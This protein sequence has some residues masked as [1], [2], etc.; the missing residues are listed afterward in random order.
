MFGR[1]V[2]MLT[3]RS[4]HDA[5]SL[6]EEASLKAD[7]GSSIRLGNGGWFSGCLPLAGVRVP[8]G[9]GRGKSSLIVPWIRA[10]ASSRSI[11]FTSSV[12]SRSSTVASGSVNAPT[13]F[14]RW[15]GRPSGSMA[16]GRFESSDSGG[17]LS[18]DGDDDDGD[19]DV[20]VAV[21]VVCCP[22]VSGPDQVVVGDRSASSMTSDCHFLTSP[23]GRLHWIGDMRCWRVMSCNAS[24]LRDRRCALK[25][26]GELTSS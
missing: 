12:V 8:D 15:N 26:G 22:P 23:F 3:G 16:W 1:S 19:D 17:G 2:A 21:A 25:L 13:R 11:N 10:M 7:D 18:S 6:W 14:S 4:S 5:A 20:D 24:A 9:V